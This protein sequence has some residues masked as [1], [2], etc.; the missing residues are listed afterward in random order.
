[1]WVSAE[2]YF[3]R[4]PRVTKHFLFWLLYVSF[5]TILYGSFSEDYFVQFQFQLLF[6]PEKVVAT[7]VVIYYFLPKYLLAKKYFL[8]IIFLAITLLLMGVLHW[9]TGVLIQQPIF[10]PE[11]QTWGPVWYPAK[12]IKSSVNI[13]PVVAIAVVIKMFQQWYSFQQSTQQLTQEKLAAELK[14]LKAQIHPHFLFNTLNNL[15]ALTLKKSDHAP[16]VVLKLSE[17][18]NYMLYDCNAKYVLLDKE[19]GMLENYIALEKIRYGDRLDVAYHVKGD[20]IGNMIAPML[21]LPFVENSFKHGVS[22]EIQEAWISIDISIFD[23]Q[24]TLKVDNSKSDR[25]DNIEE[26]SYKRG[27]GMSNVKRRLELLYED[28][29]D[30]KVI[31]TDVSFLVVLKL[32]LT[33]GEA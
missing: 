19:V 21:I 28:K 11:D 18:L 20:V 5:F 2:N 12:I 33:N 25:Q 6:L 3:N 15:Y 31:D 29:Y 9:A 1:M 17:L 4:I 7:Y 23:G 13:Y 22:E 32:D 14:F 26:N 30:L 24:L 10:Y 16:D 27:I 8:F